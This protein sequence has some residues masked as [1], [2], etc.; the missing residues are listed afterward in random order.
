MNVLGKTELGPKLGQVQGP[1]WPKPLREREEGAVEGSPWCGVPP[2]TPCEAF[3]T[4]SAA[5]GPGLQDLRSCCS[6]GPGALAQ[7][8]DRPTPHG[9]LPPGAP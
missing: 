6:C 4:N 7:M 9:W 3:Q 2:E 8:W 1:G 5:R